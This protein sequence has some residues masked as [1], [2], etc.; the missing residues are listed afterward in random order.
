MSKIN[1]VAKVLKIYAIV[2][3][4]L[5]LVSGLYWI[6]QSSNL[7]GDFGIIFVGLCLVFSFG[8]YAFGEVVQLLHDIRDRIGKTA[9]SGFTDDDLPSI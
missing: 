5:G 2:N 3:A 4:A 6:S 1:V 8:I 9:Q 7:F